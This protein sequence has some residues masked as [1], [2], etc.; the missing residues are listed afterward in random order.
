MGTVR[1]TLASG[2]GQTSVTFKMQEGQVTSV[3]CNLLLE[4]LGFPAA[5]PAEGDVEQFRMETL[6]RLAGE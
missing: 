5:C 1:H 3:A 4:I 6:G 2:V